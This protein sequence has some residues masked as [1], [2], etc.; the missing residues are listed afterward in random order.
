MHE[1]IRVDKKGEETK[2]A[3]RGGEEIFGLYRT[4]NILGGKEDD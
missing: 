1:A 3:G 4:S 2:G